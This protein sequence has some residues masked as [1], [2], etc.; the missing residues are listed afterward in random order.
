MRRS[1]KMIKHLVGLLATALLLGTAATASAQVPQILTQQGRILD[2]S[3][4]P[5][6]LPQLLTK[7][8]VRE[9]IAAVSDKNANVA[10]NF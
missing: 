7:S 5:I 10:V 6:I 8:T 3:L 9:A 2:T 1:K 4:Q